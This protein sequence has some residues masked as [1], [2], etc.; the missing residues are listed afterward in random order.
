MIEALRTAALSDSRHRQAE[1]CDPHSAHA[2]LLVAAWV[3]AKCAR[4]VLL[5]AY[6]SAAHSIHAATFFRS[7]RM[8]VKVTLPTQ[9]PNVGPGSK[10]Q[11]EFEG[12]LR[13]VAVPPSHKPGDA[14]EV[15]VPKPVDIAGAC[16]NKQMMVEV[17][18]PTQP[19]YVGPGSKLQFEFEGAARVVKVPPGYTPG[20]TFKVAVPKPVSPQSIEGCPQPTGPVLARLAPLEVAQSNADRLPHIP[21]KHA[22]PRNL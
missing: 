17:T 1:L 20:M 4:N 11:F 21:A 5:S 22:C 7:K 3:D 14:F 13:V 18:V 19:P 6:L 16:W 8:M 9:P 10:V 2:T 15:A 12:S